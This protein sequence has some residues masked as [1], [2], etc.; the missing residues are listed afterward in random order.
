MAGSKTMQRQCPLLRGIDPG[1]Y[2]Y[3]VHSYY[4]DPTDRSLVALESDYGITFTSMVWRENLFATQF[5]PEKSQAVGLRF[6][7][8]FIHL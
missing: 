3:F 6:L 5:H 4:A 8:N 2:F 7:S 1:N